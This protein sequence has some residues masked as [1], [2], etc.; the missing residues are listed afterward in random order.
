MEFISGGTNMKKDCIILDIDGCICDY[1]T[2]LLYW[3]RQSWP[4]LAQKANEHLKVDD[5]WIDYRTLGIPYREWL[6]VLEMFRCSGGKQTLPLFE[7]AK[8]L[9][10]WAM[11]H[12][13]DIVL[14]TSRPIDIH[15]NIYRDTVEW[16]RINSIHHH[17]L[18]WSKSKAEIVH[19]MRLTDRVVVAIDDELKHIQEYD[20]LGLSSV[21]IDLYKKGAI[22]TPTLCY[23]VTSMKECVEFLSR[24]DKKNEQS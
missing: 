12:K 3:L 10:F 17:L 7:G 13:Y 6:S 2:G 8:D 15:S 20:A 18:L 19:K 1:R 16:L 5:T 24:G 11:E 9:V 21:W 22:E 23:R 4:S 14:L